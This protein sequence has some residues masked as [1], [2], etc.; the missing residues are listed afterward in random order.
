[1]VQRFV[2]LNNLHNAN[3]N[4][5]GNQTNLMKFNFIRSSSDTSYELRVSF[6]RQG[7]SFLSK[8]DFIFTV[9]G[10]M[11]LPQVEASKSTTIFELQSGMALHTVQRP[12]YGCQ[13]QPSL[14]GSSSLIR[15]STIRELN[16]FC[17][18]LAFATVYNVTF[19]VE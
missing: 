8:K 18:R 12:L 2:L 5:E 10:S 16:I 17:S 13:C 3:Q 7:Y 6:R 14:I 19:P 15:S 4:R 1:M 9:H 11:K